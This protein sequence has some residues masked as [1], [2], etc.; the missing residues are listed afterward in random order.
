MTE[1]DVGD[2]SLLEWSHELDRKFLHLPFRPLQPTADVG[3]ACFLY[4][5]AYSNT[6]K[7]AGFLLLDCDA[8]SAFYEGVSLRTLGRRTQMNAATSS[9]TTATD[10]L[11]QLSSIVDAI[12]HA[13]RPDTAL[14][15]TLRTNIGLEST[16]FSSSLSII[17]KSKN[18]QVSRNLKTSFDLDP[19]DHAASSNLLSSHFV[20][21]LLALATVLGT[22]ATNEQLGYVQAS[23]SASFIEKGV[24]FNALELL[25]RSSLA[26][27]G[28]DG[29][30]SPLIGRDTVS[31]LWPLAE[32]PSF[33][34]S[35]SEY[36]YATP[37]RDDASSAC[38]AEKVLLT[39]Q[40]VRW[41][42]DLD[43][44][45]GL[46]FFGPSGCK[47]PKRQRNSASVPTQVK[48]E[49]LSSSPNLVVE[50]DDADTTLTAPPRNAATHAA[51][52][53]AIVPRNDDDTSDT[54]EEESLPL[55]GSEAD[56]K[57]AKPKVP[58]LAS[59]NSKSVKTRAK[60]EMSVHPT[61]EKQT[62]SSAETLELTPP[63]PSFDITTSQLSPTKSKAVRDEQQRRREEIARIK[64]GDDTFPD[65]S[66][67]S[68]STSA[69]LRSNT[70]SRKRS[71]F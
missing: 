39:Q 8:C 24:P 17:L 35:K 56:T 43:E 7:E 49:S 57:A 70:S 3:Q 48:L 53:V 54:S 58:V 22:S 67:A 19:L 29:K 15:S 45:D 4:K 51:R 9:S 10:E 12:H 28:L 50:D 30:P 31:T 23:H 32:Q 26:S 69:S 44:D 20:R 66:A 21:P 52:A 64:R 27:A 38:Q 11:Q 63:P 68:T 37:T 71:R 16:R 1:S 47:R 5:L 60:T 41:N 62:S 65:S 14:D 13:L 42:S 59:S 25:R 61:T 6:N 36:I 33:R 40:D 2:A 55:L 18:D 46:L 34:D